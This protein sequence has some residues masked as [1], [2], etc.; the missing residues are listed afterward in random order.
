VKEVTF[1]LSEDVVALDQ[2][3]VS[4]S[5]TRCSD[6]IVPLVNVITPDLF[7]T[8]NASCLSEGLNFQP[9]VGLKTIARIVALTRYV[10]TGWTA[11]IHKS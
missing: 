2:V 7:E 8:A 1:E 9:G 11:I 3:V 6:A 5:R 10:L 4:A